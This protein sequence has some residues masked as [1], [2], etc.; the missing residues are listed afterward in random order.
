[1]SV[2]KTVDEKG[3]CT[4]PFSTTTLTLVYG[5]LEY[6]RSVFGTDAV[7]RDMI[8]DYFAKARES[9]P[10]DAE[11]ATLQAAVNEA[12]KSGPR[13]CNPSQDLATLRANLVKNIACAEAR[14]AINRRCFPPAGDAGHRQAAGD[15]RKAAARCQALIAQKTGAAPSACSQGDCP[16]NASR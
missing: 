13:A 6:I 1:M 11:H 10:T 9:W 8:I 3:S 16:P 4:I 2:T 15:D 12:C 14:E 5:E 7:T